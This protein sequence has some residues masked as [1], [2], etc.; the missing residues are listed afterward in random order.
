MQSFQTLSDA[1]SIL[2]LI[3][4]HF[5]HAQAHYEGKRFKEAYDAYFTILRTTTSFVASCPADQTVNRWYQICLDNA[6]AC[7]TLIHQNEPS[8]IAIIHFIHQAPETINEAPKIKLAI[9]K[10]M[11]YLGQYSQIQKELEDL[12]P[13][14]FKD[15]YRAMLDFCKMLSGAYIYAN[16]HRKAERLWE[17]C[18]HLVVGRSESGSEKGQAKTSET[19]ETPETP[20]ISESQLDYTQD[21]YFH[22]SKMALMKKNVTGQIDAL[23]ASIQAFHLYATKNV[24]SPEL[25]EKFIQTFVQLLEA[26]GSQS[27]IELMSDML[28]HP[29]TLKAIQQAKRETQEFALLAWLQTLR[30]MTISNPSSSILFINDYLAF[31][32]RQSLTSAHPSLVS[33]ACMLQAMNYLLCDPSSPT[34]SLYFSQL[35]TRYIANVTLDVHTIGHISFKNKIY[36]AI[37]HSQLSQGGR[38]YEL[39]KAICDDVKSADNTTK[40]VIQLELK[41]VNK[42][43][44]GT[45]RYDSK[46]IAFVKEVLVSQK[47]DA[48]IV[49][50]L[51][52][53]IAKIDVMNEFVRLNTKRDGIDEDD[54]LDIAVDE[55]SNDFI[56]SLTELNQAITFLSIC[57]SPTPGAQITNAS[58][59]TTTSR[60]TSRNK[61]YSGK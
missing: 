36:Q 11:S 38:Y 55:R 48:E 21:I 37:A 34:I 33:T 59:V 56:A 53:F 27:T 9:A 26:C 28:R 6:I 58:A 2:A 52:E 51:S 49:D 25:L 32:N 1:K 42:Q 44:A 15:D 31:L 50:S 29:T 13:S 45:H 8:L 3:K 43:V 20:E 16:E 17:K 14:D 22:L 7:A 19:P 10:A 41:F 30:A 18:K 4:K 12:E 39:I 40:G 24:L 46:K 61:P 35:S 54:D 5:A 57:R 47:I 60:S 23:R